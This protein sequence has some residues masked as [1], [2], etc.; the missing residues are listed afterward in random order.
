MSAV[1][2]KSKVTRLSSS[3]LLSLYC[4]GRCAIYRYELRVIIWNTADVLLEETSIT[5]ERMSDIYVKGWVAGFDEPQSTDIHYRSI[6][7]QHCFLS[8]VIAKHFCVISKQYIFCLNFASG[9]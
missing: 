9:V 3:L 2:V 1:V 5:G 7:L 4:S 8:R 6:S